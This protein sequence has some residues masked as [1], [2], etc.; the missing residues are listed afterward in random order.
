MKKNFN[1]IQI[2][3]FRGIIMAIFIVTC[4]SAGFIVFPGWLCMQIWNII[5]SYT[6]NIPLIALLQGILLGGLL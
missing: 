5:A 3:G 6:L 4:L 2:K 1:V